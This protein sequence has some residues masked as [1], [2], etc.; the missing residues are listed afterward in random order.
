MNFFL[1]KSKFKVRQWD[2]VL[3]YSCMSLDYDGKEEERL[4]ETEG[5]FGSKKI[6]V[7]WR[8]LLIYHYNVLYH[9]DL[10]RMKK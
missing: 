1:K 6:I 3:T 10:S 4:W 9:Y 8:E 7:L 2:N 5:R